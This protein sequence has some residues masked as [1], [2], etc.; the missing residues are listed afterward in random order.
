MKYFKVT[1]LIFQSGNLQAKMIKLFTCQIPITSGV[2]LN[3]HIPLILCSVE[4]LAWC[5]NC[6]PKLA[7]RVPE[8]IVISKSLFIFNKGE[9]EI[10]AGDYIPLFH[11]L[12][13]IRVL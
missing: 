5:S 2:I 3:E 10:W 6:C 4:V 9:A 1:Y 11:Y 12:L 13:S 7:K 8:H